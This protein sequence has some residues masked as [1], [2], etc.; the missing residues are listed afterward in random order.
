MRALGAGAIALVLLG[1]GGGKPPAPPAPPPVPLHLAPA[2]DL[3]PAAG[4]TWLLDVKPR[5]LA[6][7]PDLIPVIGAVVSEARFRAYAEA[8]G[9]IDPRQIQ[10]LCVGRFKASTL[11]VARVPFDPARVERTFTDRSAAPPRRSIVVANPPVVR[12]EGEV[13]GEPEH[14][15]LFG[16][17][18]VA[19]ESGR[20]ATLRAA[21][22]FA[23]GRLRKATPALASKG[24]GPVADLLGD[25]PIRFLVP[26]PFEGDAAAGLGGLLRA[27][28]AVGVSARPTGA[29]S[30]IAVRIVLGGA[31][32]DDADAA[33]ERL[34]AAVHV[35]SETALGRMLGVDHPLD[36]PTTRAAPDALVLDA[37]VD[38]MRFAE[39]AH[40]V[41]EADIAQILR[42]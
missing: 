2:C 10:E 12:V 41:L 42:R 3:V 1:C 5:A 40:D 27:T 31:W 36:G 19:E 4:L 20:L 23:Q 7:T 8:H 34:A 13:L 39:G 15:T 38:G 11:V 26:G 9:G 33:R 17:E 37:V 35:L 16:R 21:E 29:G 25:A 18:L 32:G 6:E 28:T 30:R 22:A 14:V 24:V